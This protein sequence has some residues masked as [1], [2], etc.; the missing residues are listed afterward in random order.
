[1]A[2][3][4][5]QTARVIIGASPEFGVP[6]AIATG[7]TVYTGDLL[8]VASDKVF[9]VDSD[10]AEHGR[11]VAG[12]GGAAGDIIPCHTSAII[13]GFSGATSAAPIYPGATAGQYTETADVTAGDSNE[14][15]GYMLT[16]TIA[17]VVPAVRADSVAS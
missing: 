17:M 3:A 6:M 11:L 8:G 15:V 13:G 2:F 10:D 9:P 4:D 12:R 7:E 1:M 16:D 14:I 5:N